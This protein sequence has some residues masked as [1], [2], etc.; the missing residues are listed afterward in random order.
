MVRQACKQKA[1]QEQSMEPSRPPLDDGYHPV[2]PGKIATVVTYLEM[3]ARPAL[4]QAA[5][6]DLTFERLRGRDAARYRALFRAVGED[7]LWFSRLVMP[8]AQLAAILDDTNVEAFAC[9]SDGRE[10][11]LMELDFRAG[12][13]AELA[14]FGLVPDAI[15]SGAAGAMMAEALARAWARPIR[16][17]MVHTCTLDHPRAVGFYRKWGFVPYRLA[18]EI[19]DDPRLTGLAKPDARADIPAIGRPPGS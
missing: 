10:T 7:W 17:L 16:R 15:G 5:T 8:E 19:A 11:G 12:D 1:A 14:F 18:V 6:A 4:P 3:H 9:L 2:P 13:D